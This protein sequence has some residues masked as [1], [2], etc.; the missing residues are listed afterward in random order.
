MDALQ[1]KWCALFL[2]CLIH[3]NLKAQESMPSTFE[4]KQPLSESVFLLDSPPA[5]FS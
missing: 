1:K 5:L 3:A 2:G 4:L